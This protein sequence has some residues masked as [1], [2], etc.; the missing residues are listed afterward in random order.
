MAELT[1][2]SNEA[3]VLGR[4]RWLTVL[5]AAGVAPVVAACGRPAFSCAEAPGL[6]P[7]EATARS[8]FGYLDR[9][10]VVARRCEAC[11]HYVAVSGPAC[12]TCRLVRGPIHPD[13]TCN[14]FAAKT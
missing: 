3:P 11:T 5:A 9:S 10:N 12:G 2:L 13:G 1:E 7:P 4:R 6:A 8:T 14:V